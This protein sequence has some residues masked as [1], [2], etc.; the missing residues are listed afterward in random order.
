MPAAPCWWC[1]AALTA[2]D[3]HILQPPQP[4]SGLAAL[5][6]PALAAM[7]H[8]PQPAA[9]PP[10]PDV[11]QS[12]GG[13]LGAQDLLRACLSGLRQQVLQ[14]QAPPPPPGLDLARLLLGVQ[15]LQLPRQPA[16]FIPCAPPAWPSVPPPPPHV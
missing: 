9:P 1:S 5:L 4:L 11:L 14:P 10:T 2:A 13:L 8:A 15:Q 3:Q 16:G 6:L 7:Y 12:L